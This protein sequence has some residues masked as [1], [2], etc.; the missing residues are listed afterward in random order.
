MGNVSLGSNIS[1]GGFR[2]DTNNYVINTGANT[3]SFAATN[4]FIGFRSVAAATITGDVSGS[5]N[6]SI[7]LVNPIVGTTLTPFT[8]TLNGTSAGGWS[9]TTTIG[10]LSTLA[11][12][13]SNQALLNTTGGITLNGGGITLTNIA[14]QASLDRVNNSAITSN[15]GTITYTNANTAST[16]YTETLGSTALTSGRLNLVLT[17][18]VNATDASQTLTLSGLTRTGATNSSTVAFAANGS[19]NTTNNRIAI[20]GASDGFVGPWA[21]VGTSAT[22]QT[23]YAF[24]TDVSGTKYVTAANIGATAENSGS[25]VGGANVTLSGAT[26]LT[27]T[28]TV[29]SLRYTGGGLSLALGGSSFNLETYGILNGGSGALTISNAGRARSPLPPAV[30]SSI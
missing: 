6:V 29:N 16:A 22:A 17:N 26:T 21:T 10:A 25:W 3:L 4:N 12:A 14:A 8:L 20:G 13:D 15:G 30:V 19:L 5:G 9:G 1:V 27:A 24:I 23:D 28:R 11:L 2:F 18:N 7:G